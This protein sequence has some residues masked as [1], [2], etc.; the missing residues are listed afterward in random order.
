MLSKLKIINNTLINK[1]RLIA[2]LPKMN[3]TI[4][5]TRVR[6]EVNNNAIPK[7]LMLNQSAGF[8]ATFNIVDCCFTLRAAFLYFIF[9]IF[10]NKLRNENIRFALFDPLITNSYAF[11]RVFNCRAKTAPV[12]RA[13]TS[14]ATITYYPTA[15][16]ANRTSNRVNILFARP[17]MSAPI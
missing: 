2:I 13:T 11:I 4:I 15:S 14:R 17:T 9:S 8:K 6:K 3:N 1:K 16:W 5:K 7:L 12:I 10:P